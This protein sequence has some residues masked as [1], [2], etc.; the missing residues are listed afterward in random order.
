MGEILEIASFIATPLGAILAIAAIP[1]L[2]FSAGGFSKIE[3][4]LL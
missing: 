4:R 2:Y 1:T 3:D